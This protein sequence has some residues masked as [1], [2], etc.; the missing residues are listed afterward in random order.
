MIGD[1]A[2]ARRFRPGPAEHARALGRLVRIFRAEAP[3]IVHAYLAAA[4]VLGPV[5][6]R[7]A[8]VPRVIVSKR[9][10]TFYQEAFPL[11]RFL[12][13]IGSLLA[14]V[15]MVNSDAV[16]R[17]VALTEPNREGKFRRI[18]NGVGPIPRWTPEEIASFRAREGLP[19]TA[20][21][22]VCVSNFF[23]YK[24]HVDLVAALARIVG[25]FPNATCVLIGR[26][27]GS[28]AATRALA[29]D[30]GVL[31]RLRFAG[32]RDDVPDFLRAADL[33]VH[34]SHQEGFSNAILEA[35]AAGLPVVACDVGGNPEAVVDGAT[36][37]LVPPRSPERLADAMSEFF[38]DEGKRSGDGGGGEAPRRR[39]FLPRTDGGRGRGD[40]RIACTA[41]GRGRVSAG[42]VRPYYG[43]K[44]ESLRDIFGAAEV[45]AEDRRIVVDGRGY[46]VIDDVIVLLPQEQWPAGVRARISG[47]AGQPGGTPGNGFA[48]D[49]QFT[50]GEE[51]RCFPEILPEHEKE[52]QQYFDLVNLDSLANARICDL[53]CGIG[54]WSHFLKGRCREMV[55]L[56]FSEAIF[57]ARENLR[58]ASNALFFLGDLRRMPFR[59]DFADFLFTLGVLHHLAHRRIARG[60]G[61]LPLRAHSPRLPVLRIGQPAGVL[62]WV[63][64]RRHGGRFALSRTEGPR[65]PVGVD[66][67]AHDRRLPA[68]DP[69]GA[70]RAPARVGE[71]G[72][73]VRFL[74]GKIAPED[75]P[76]RVRP[77]LHANRAAVPERGDPRP[78]GHVPRC[79]CFRR[80]ALLALPVPQGIDPMNPFARNGGNRPC[81]G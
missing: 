71:Q 78:S 80:S 55:L 12:E 66:L 15:V 58:G 9:S 79:R 48:K 46:P 29:G 62:A 33:F 31:P 7:L 11:L 30:L 18:Y 52:F 5:A 24:G 59:D 50:F 73:V 64:L 10:G 35:M 57:V 17:E 77:I 40:V 36:G 22:A 23:D 74:P 39:A 42:E 61:A 56:D 1:P 13:R 81:A 53:G 45:R 69:P 54:R 20:P 14:D 6:A 72:S 16:R 63:A 43:D 49:I 37:R 25:D 2:H 27:A 8:G 34:P 65:S 75:T 44:L 76:G 70:R 26:D 21:M 60:P 67:G 28:L 38:G 4:N 19:P 3:D 41:Q 51:W 68:A 32:P 47:A